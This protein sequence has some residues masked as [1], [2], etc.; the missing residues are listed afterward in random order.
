MLTG[1][2]EKPSEKYKRITLS[3]LNEKYPDDEFFVKSYIPASW[4][5]S[6]AELWV[7]S[8]KYKER[9]FQVQVTDENSSYT[10]VDNYYHLYMNYDANSFFKSIVN[11][12]NVT[13][14]VRFPGNVWSNEIDRY[15]TFKDYVNSGESQIDV[16]FILDQESF[17]E[18]QM[19]EIMKKILENKI[20]GQFYFI[21]IKPLCFVD[22]DNL[23]YECII[24]DYEYVIDHNFELTKR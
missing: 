12:F 15:K 20:V 8:T 16:L 11:D 4:A 14:D 10:I 23:D 21:E 3:Y 19:D 1:C 2:F 9:M 17:D 24:S 13:L 6:Y 5:Y 18:E 7:S 22:W